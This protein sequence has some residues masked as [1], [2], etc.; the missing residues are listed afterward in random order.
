Q[1]D[2]IFG[3][4]ECE[5]G[6]GLLVVEQRAGA[7]VVGGGDEDVEAAV[8]VEVEG[9]R[10]DV[11]VIVHGGGAGAMDA[12]GLGAGALE[13]QGGAVG[14]V[15]DLRGVGGGADVP[16]HDFGGEQIEAAVVV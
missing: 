10:G 15:E 4:D 7:R 1:V 2:A 13:A 3:G 6:V 9:G 14:V 5:G 12:G 11:A 8:V 16:V